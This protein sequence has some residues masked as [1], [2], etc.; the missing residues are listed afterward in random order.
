MKILRSSIL[1]IYF[2]KKLDLST[3]GELRKALINL[4]MFEE[5]PKAFSGVKCFTLQ[6]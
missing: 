2:K 4:G 5:L 6:K 3:L 1:F